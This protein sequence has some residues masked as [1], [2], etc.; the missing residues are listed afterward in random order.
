MNH[1]TVNVEIEKAALRSSGSALM[2]SLMEMVATS[3][4]ASRRRSSSPQPSALWVETIMQTPSA[5]WVGL[6]T[7]VVLGLGLGSSLKVW[8]PGL[9]RRHWIR[10]S[11]TKAL[12]DIELFALFCNPI[13][14]T[15]LNLR[16]LSFGQDLKFIMRTMP[17]DQLE[18]EPAASLYTTRRGLVLHRPR[19]LMFSGHTLGNNLAFETPDGHL[20][21]EATASRLVALLRSLLPKTEHS[22]ARANALELLEAHLKKQEEFALSMQHCSRSWMMAAAA[23]RAAAAA[24]CATTAG[25]QRD[26]LTRHDPKLALSRLQ[27]IVLNCCNSL[28]IGRAL[29]HAAPGTCVVCWSTLTEDSAARAFIVGFLTYVADVRPQAPDPPPRFAAGAGSL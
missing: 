19:F 21:R 22:A 13:L 6:M 2:P 12:A 4:K 1:K 26:P 14:P 8:K 11:R 9:F 3:C 29:V 15:S 18:V 7:G 23:E 20:D 28:D 25:H 24:T 16:P 27:C 10:W 17:A 5:W